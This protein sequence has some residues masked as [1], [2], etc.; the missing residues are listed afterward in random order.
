MS[1][2]SQ[3]AL[4]YCLELVKVF[5]A[6]CCSNFWR[7]KKN[8]FLQFYTQC[9]AARGGV[10]SHIIKQV[11]APKSSPEKYY[12]ILHVVIRINYI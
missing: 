3:T 11:H 8:S 12:Y 7:P 5:S 10:T 6:F 2:Q 9:I 1:Q 4:L